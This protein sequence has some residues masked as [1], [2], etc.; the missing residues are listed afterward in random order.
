MYR[1]TKPAG[2]FVRL[3][4]DGIAGVLHVFAEPVSRAATREQRRGRNR[5]QETEDGFLENVH[6]IPFVF[7]FNFHARPIA[8]LRVPGQLR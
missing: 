3:V 5:Q 1:E 4:L 6:F 8:A 2:L 7:E